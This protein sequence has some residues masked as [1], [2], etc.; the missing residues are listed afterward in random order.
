MTKLASILAATVISTTFA[1]GAMASD[2]QMSVSARDNQATAYVTQHG[3]ALGS[4]PVDVQGQHYVTDQ[5]G[6][7][8]YKNHAS[9]AKTVKFATKD[10]AGNPVEKT[11]FVGRDND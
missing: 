3:Q 7:V 1:A 4:Y 9:N 11:T 5:N 8:T 2:L 10:S 6:A